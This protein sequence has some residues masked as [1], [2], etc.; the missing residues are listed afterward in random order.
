MIDFEKEKSNRPRTPEERMRKALSLAPSVATSEQLQYL[1]AI[2]DRIEGTYLNED[3][4][5]RY[6]QIYE[7]VKDAMEIPGAMKIEREEPNKN[8]YA[9]NIMLYCADVF[10]TAK[11]RFKPL[12]EA[13]ELADEITVSAEN[14]GLIFTFTVF[15][16]WQE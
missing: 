4:L 15:D 16:I 10:G 14:G 12:L 11:S 7:L 9:A 5:K 13:I 3:N 8:H 2:N 6:D 1:A